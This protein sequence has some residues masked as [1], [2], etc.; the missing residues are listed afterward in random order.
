MLQRGRTPASWF[1]WCSPP[2]RHKRRRVVGA[3]AA[4]DRLDTVLEPPRMI[5]IEAF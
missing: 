5:R 3:L 4:I 2:T 1:P